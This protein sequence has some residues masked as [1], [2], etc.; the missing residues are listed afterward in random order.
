MIK[1]T[2]AFAPPAGMSRAD[3]QRHYAEKHGPLVGSVPSFARHVRRYLQNEIFD[4]AGLAATPLA[5]VSE[6]WFDDWDSYQ[7]A[8][9]EPAYVERIRPDE[10]NFAAMEGIVILFADEH[11]VFG[12]DEQSPITLF[13]ILTR[14]QQVDDERL[15]SV[16]LADYRRA[17]SGDPAVRRLCES[18]SQNRAVDPGLNPFALS[19]PYDGIDAF[20]FAT[21]HQIAPF[22]EAEQRIAQA[23]SL[24]GVVQWTQDMMFAARVTVMHG[25]A[26]SL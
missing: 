10:E 22:L 9:A 16:W 18:Y 1:F 23:V 2:I 24:R 3:C 17:L 7:R 8:F 14:V 5:G 25:Y 15:N 12:N 21:V 4:V 11:R 6:L 26:P 20:G 13:R 19:R